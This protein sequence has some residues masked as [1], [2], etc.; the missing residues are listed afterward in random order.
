MNN[1]SAF[2]REFS[3]IKI[4]IIYK[5]TEKEIPNPVITFG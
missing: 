1:Q 5:Y 2:R 3:W 4:I